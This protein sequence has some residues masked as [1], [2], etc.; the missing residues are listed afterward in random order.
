MYRIMS[1]APRWML[2]TV[3]R[4][5]TRLPFSESTLYRGKPRERERERERKRERQKTGILSSE[6]F[7]IQA[8]CNEARSFER[9]KASV[10][11]RGI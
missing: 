9:S 7:P 5:F 6:P 1:R 10:E 2:V 4:I 8:G 3:G 11:L